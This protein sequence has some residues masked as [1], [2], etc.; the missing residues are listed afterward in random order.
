MARE[1]KEPK[2]RAEWQEAVDLAEGALALSDAREHYKLIEGGPEVDVARCEDIL[3]RGLKRGIRPV[4]NAAE[5]FVEA[6]LAVQRRHR[7]SQLQQR[8]RDVQASRPSSPEFR[9]PA[10][11]SEL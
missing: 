6:H 8:P 11:G 4:E 3:A 10:K 7:A 5:R 1:R 2:T 9:E